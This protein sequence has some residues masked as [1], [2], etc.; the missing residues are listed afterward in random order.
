MQSEET[1][2]AKQSWIFE[3]IRQ[4][5]SF[6]FHFKV[7]CVYPDNPGS[8]S[9]S[10]SHDL[11]RV[12]PTCQHPNLQPKI[13]QP[14]CQ[15]YGRQTMTSGTME[16]FIPEIVGFRFYLC[17]T[18]F[19]R[20]GFRLTPTHTQNRANGPLCQRKKRRTSDISYVRECKLIVINRKCNL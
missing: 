7:S 12:S 17:M 6:Y 20:N 9:C 3:T 4:A 13:I 16:F 15:R 1:P 2:R 18:A 19:F 14:P 8:H 5:G 11:W 10:D